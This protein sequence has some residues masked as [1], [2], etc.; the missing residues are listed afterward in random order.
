MKGVL[1]WL[2]HGAPRGSTRDLCPALAALVGPVQNSFSSLYLN[3]IVSMSCWVSCLLICVYG[4]T[5]IDEGILLLSP[6]SMFVTLMSWKFFSWSR[7]DR[8]RWG[9]R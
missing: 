2:V 1:S 7:R 3:S 9:G 8:I 5:L 6:N 4:H